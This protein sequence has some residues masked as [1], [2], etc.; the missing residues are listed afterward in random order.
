[1]IT[2]ESREWLIKF[3]S[4]L[5]TTTDDKW[6]TGVCRST[7]KE[8]NCVMGHLFRMNLDDDEQGRLWWDWFEGCVATTFMIY[9]VNDGGDPRYPQTTPKARILAYLND[10]LDGKVKTSYDYELE[11]ARMS[12]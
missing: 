3:I 2:G 4:Y 9:P 12:P 10:V 6:T 8:K 7:T 5:E 1:M 11:Q